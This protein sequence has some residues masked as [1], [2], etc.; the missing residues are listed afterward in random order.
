MLSFAIKSVNQELSHL[1]FE[2]DDDN[3]YA[4]TFICNIDGKQRQVDFEKLTD[5]DIED[6]ITFLRSKKPEL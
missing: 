3:E 1:Y 4:L 5:S 6:M 2:K